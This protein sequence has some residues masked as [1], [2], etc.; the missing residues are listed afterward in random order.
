MDA[1][2]IMSHENPPI[3]LLSPQSNYVNWQ[4]IE[5]TLDL[6]NRYLHYD[7]YIK[8]LKTLGENAIVSIENL[9]HRKRK[10]V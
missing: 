5:S 3:S 9:T 2:K 8:R 6:G 7:N 4:T 10:V 1:L